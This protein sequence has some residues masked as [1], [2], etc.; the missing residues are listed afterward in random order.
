MKWM[1]E[2]SISAAIFGTLYKCSL[3][4]NIMGLVPSLC[5]F[6]GSCEFSIVEW[7]VS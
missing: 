2:L 3:T 5:V 4:L 6:Q 7:F 1:Y